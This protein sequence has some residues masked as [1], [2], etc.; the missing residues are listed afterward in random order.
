MANK[1]LLS[2]DKTAFPEEDREKLLKSMLESQLATRQAKQARASQVRPW[3]F[4]TQYVRAIKL[5]AEWI[6][7]ADD[8]QNLL[9]PPV[10]TQARAQRFIEHV[11]S[12]RAA[13]G[14]PPYALTTL[15]VMLQGVALI[16]RR[17]HLLLYGDPNLTQTVFS[18]NSDW[19]RKKN[20]SKT[21][22]GIYEG[23]TS[24]ASMVQPRTVSMDEV[25]FVIA[26]LHQVRDMSEFDVAVLRPAKS[27]AR[28]A[29]GSRVAK[30]AEAGLKR[31]VTNA[32]KAWEKSMSAS[33]RS[34]T[35]ALISLMNATWWRSH[36]LINITFSALRVVFD[37]QN[38]L[39]SPT[40]EG[41]PRVPL[42]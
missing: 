8:N 11:E 42:L 1:N 15:Q 31:R 26:Q 9:A 25:R 37:T 12:V 14:A 30:N 6:K 17:E 13:T 24:R 39:G 23:A 4:V 19:L 41:A 21:H 18:L 28:R 35:C 16:E 36:Q 38:V 27:K 40:H 3:E 29:T 2:A 33:Y 10:V 32:Q 20:K 22:A 5:Y 34:L 7:I